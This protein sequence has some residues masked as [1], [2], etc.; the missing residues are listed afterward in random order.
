MG[1]F[2]TPPQAA[3]PTTIDV[4]LLQEVSRARLMGWVHSFFA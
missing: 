1:A 2:K 4:P 3:S